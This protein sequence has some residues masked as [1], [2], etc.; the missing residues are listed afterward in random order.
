MSL[1]PNDLQAIAE[2]NKQAISKQRNRE[3]ER[4]PDASKYNKGKYP[5]RKVEE[6]VGGHR[7]TVDSTPG[8]RVMERYHGSGTYEQW[9]EDG[10]E[11]KV[12][13]GNVQQHM[14]EGY[15]LSIDQNGDIRIE[16]HARLVIGG[17]AH[18][19]VKGDMSMVVTGDMSQTVTG[20]FNQ[21]VVGDMITTVGGK[22]STISQGDQLTKTDANF[23]TQAA[24]N[25]KMTAGGTSDMES[26]G[27]MTKKAPRIDLNP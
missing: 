10:T 17:G 24:S 25:Y 23:T 21:V 5:M 7:I 26:K 19:E 27:N 11:T 14:K 6:H 4:T 22:H 2:S 1:D 16:G 15:T 3:R 18:I 9:S 12:V 13:V 20:N 8:H